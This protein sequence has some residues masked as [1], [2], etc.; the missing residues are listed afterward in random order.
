MRSRAGSRSDEKWSATEWLDGEC[1][2][3][4]TTIDST[5]NRKNVVLKATN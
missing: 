3:Q 1:M 4:F 2:R 5:D